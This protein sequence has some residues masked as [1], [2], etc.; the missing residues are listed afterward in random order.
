MAILIGFEFFTIYKYKNINIVF[1][2]VIIFLA[3]K[4][5]QFW[6]LRNYG[7]ILEFF[8]FFSF[9]ILFTSYLKFFRKKLIALLILE[10]I[11]LLII[12]SFYTLNSISDFLAPFLLSVIIVLD[13]VFGI[14]LLI[15]SGRSANLN[16]TCFNFC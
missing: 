12:F 16:S 2:I 1:I 5:L 7:N 10:A 13:R 8:L 9:F 4:K 11:F 6:V 3:Y 15:S 14:S